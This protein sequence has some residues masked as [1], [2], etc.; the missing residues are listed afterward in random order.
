M[1]SR[2][3]RPGVPEAG[4][5]GYEWRVRVERQG[6]V[7]FR[8]ARQQPRVL[9]HRDDRQ[10]ACPGAGIEL[11]R[12]GPRAQSPHVAGAALPQPRQRER[13]LE[14]VRRDPLVVAVF[15]QVREHPLGPAG[16]EFDRL[17]WQLAGAQCLPRRRVDYV[18]H[19]G[20]RLVRQRPGLAEERQQPGRVVAQLAQA[21]FRFGDI[22]PERVN[23]CVGRARPGG[24]VRRR[25]QLAH[26]GLRADSRRDPGELRSVCPEVLQV[27]H[28]IEERRGANRQRD[29]RGVPPGH[30]EQEAQ[31]GHE[32]VRGR[33]GEHDRQA[34]RRQPG[35][36]EADVPAEAHAD[37]YLHAPDLKANPVAAEFDRVHPGA[38]QA[39]RRRV[40]QFVRHHARQVG[41]QQPAG[42]AD[43][44]PRAVVP[45]LVGSEDLPAA[46][47]TG[48]EDQ[49]PREPGERTPHELRMTRISARRRCASQS[50]QWLRIVPS[51]RSGLRTVG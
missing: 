19:I 44:R 22:E 4:E 43:K 27:G 12:E 26:R 9:G 35:G 13:W 2:R 42:V 37:S 34:A 46:E 36:V 14:L 48:Q 25:D 1:R 8:L 38:G 18:Q 40:T 23:Q 7:Q 33:A 24:P 41:G 29:E 30:G 31:R 11:G 5:R 49:H 17:G 50:R 3:P 20:L 47:E 39:H 28:E 21:V 45:W 15:G 6:L 16:R 10:R 32:Q 51:T